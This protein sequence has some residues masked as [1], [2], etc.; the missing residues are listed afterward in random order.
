MS[1]IDRI[2]EEIVKAMKSGDREA[3][4]T[5]RGIKSDLKY[6]QIEKKLKKLTDEDVV[7]VISVSAKKRKDSI[8]QFKAG[9]RDDL[10][11]KETRELELLKPF[12]PEELSPEKIEELVTAAIEESGATNPSEMGK[13]MKV[14]MP[15]VKGRADGK[16]VQQIVVKALN[17]NK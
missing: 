4:T 12:L 9:G 16:L 15:Q 14:L 13:V 3:A 1:L 7:A 17:S 8:T 10:V 6:F 2:N 11:A 5:F